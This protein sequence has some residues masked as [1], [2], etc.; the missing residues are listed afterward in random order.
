MLLIGLCNGACV[1]RAHTHTHTFTITLLHHAAPCMLLPAAPC[2]ITLLPAACLQSAATYTTWKEVNIN[3]IDTPGHVDFTI[4]V[5]R[6]LRVLDGAVLVLC[7]VG[8]VQSQTLTVNRQMNRC[9][10]VCVPVG[11]C[12]C[13]CVCVCRYGVPCLGFI[14]KLDR[15][16]ANPWRVLSQMRC[17]GC[18]C[19]CVQSQR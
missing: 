1:F 17:V 18:V 16:G 5:E 19:V 14:N 4:E 8:G 15:M 10:C 11:V 6:S 7:A 3:L 12:V 13:V 9:V 2:C